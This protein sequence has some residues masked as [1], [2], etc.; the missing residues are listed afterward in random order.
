MESA[1]QQAYNELCA[2]TLA[3]ALTDPAFIHQHVVDAFAAQHADDRSKP[4]SLWFAL[5]GLYL[6]LEKGLTGRQVQR[7]HM[8][9]ARHKIQWPS[10]ALPTERGSITAVEVMAAAPGPGRDRA[11]DAWC[12]AVWNAYAETRNAVI[13][14]LGERGI[15]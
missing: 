2:Y 3:H 12:A 10:C 5:A 11:I 14:F 1:E 4:I 9:L 7:A 13:E 15:V 8:Q 6:H